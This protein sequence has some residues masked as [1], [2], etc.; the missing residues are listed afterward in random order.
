MADSDIERLYE[1][2]ESRF[3]GKYRGKV[4]S[5]ADPEGMGRIEVQV[6]SV[7]GPEPSWALPCVPYAHADH[8][9]HA[10]PPVGASVWVEFE[11][12]ERDH[13]IWSGCF[14]A[15][16]ERPPET[17]ADVIVLKT[18]GATIRVE[19]TGTIEI[20]TSGGTKVTLSSEQI[21]LEAPSI[22]QSA[23][24][25]STEVSAA[26]FDAQNGAFTVI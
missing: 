22:K 19:H 26:G 15:T 5:T 6:P 21:K 8:G 4:V 12:G 14:W 7:M 18:P 2:M 17:A 24:G 20:E 23:N 25:G 16:G 9:W 1:A 13:P 11:A 10:I 3:F